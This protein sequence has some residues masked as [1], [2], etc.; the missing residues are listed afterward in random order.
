MTV[1][2][3]VGT[4]P[5][6]S[7]PGEHALLGRAPEIAAI[8]ALL[9]DP[10]SAGRGLLLRGPA[11]SGTSAL[12]SHARALAASRETPVLTITGV[13]AEQ[14]M[15][16][17]GLHQL[18][19]T[20]VGARRAA[21]E[22]RFA[23]A[24]DTFEA[25]A[26]L[27][28]SGPVLILAD[29]AELI[30]TA[31]LD[32]LGFVARRLS[33]T[34]VR[35]L[36]AARDGEPTALDDA[37]LDEIAVQPLPEAVARDL[38]RRTAPGLGSAWRRRILADAEGLPLA[39]VEL[40][41]AIAADPE[42]ALSLPPETLPLTPR[43]KR[44]GGCGPET[45]PPARAL[46]LAA[47]LDP[48]APLP[49][50]LAAGAAV[51]GEPV[52]LAALD[53]SL[54][55][56]LVTLRE[57]SVRFRRAIDRAAVASSASLG[58]RH[59]AHAALAEHVGDE[60]DSRARHLAAM[61]IEPDAALAA[62]VERAASG[63]YATGDVLDAAR[64]LQRSAELSPDDE[65]RRRRLT[66]A[67]GQA[68]ELGFPRAALRLLDHADAAQASSAG[69]ARTAL[70]RRIVDA[71]LWSPVITV[72]SLRDMGAEIAAAG[73][74]DV[75]LDAL[76]PVALKCWWSTSSPATR[77]SLADT[78]RALTPDPDDPRRLAI[79]GLADG[80]E[81]GPEVLERIAGLRP[82]ELGDPLR[83]M[84][85]GMAASGVGAWQIASAFLDPAIA[86][87]RAQ[88]RVATLTRA[89]SYR[90]WAALSTGDWT[91]ATQACDEVGPLARSTQQPQYLLLSELIAIN[92]AALRGVED[93][94]EERIAAIEGVLLELKQSSMLA[95]ARLAR[96]A[97]AL[98]EGRHDDAFEH[99][100][101]VFDPADMPFH[102]SVR[103]WAV[104]DLVDA[105]VHSGH[106]DAVA[107]IADGLEPL[108]QQTRGT[109]LRAAWLCTRPLLAGDDEADECFREAL[110]VELTGWP[111][112]RARTLFAHGVWLRRQRQ[113]AESRRPLRAARDLFDMLGAR[114]WS[115][116]A[117]QELR[118]TGETGGRRADDSREQLTAQEE[119][120]ARLAAGGMSN[121][122]I[123]ERLFLSHRTIGSHLY[124]IYPK[125]GISSRTD[126]REA[127]DAYDGA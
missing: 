62:A 115:E 108:A 30:D 27:S 89:L 1:A 3:P 5:A 10:P 99:L 16:Y 4:E 100:R 55:A 64:L 127:L 117:R 69:R 37:R 92:V 60:P 124:R 49:A 58:E 113:V 9:D 23:V 116:R 78:A 19:P 123:G 48:R 66:L 118:A 85:V 80:D 73:D 88:G 29:D 14:D 101:P 11:G 111:Y 65:E 67:A 13:A 26:R 22:D 39:I 28:A 21:G 71:S 76:V 42:L 84:F 126:L 54:A 50:V 18:L 98:G 97:A 8:E 2:E 96:A 79:L 36:A 77:R 86:G 43:L 45:A 52:D 72:R 47:S 119:Q 38:L 6:G 105:G 41:Q 104:L 90:A 81:T 63:A 91:T 51:C 59:A 31:T 40:G 20:T 32:V 114:R 75:A 82:H 53:P 120:I 17:A 61:A 107:A 112:L 57:G 68:F 103:T 87:L 24:T 74:A 122:E 44:A 15:P 35:L 46:L 106:H 110:G 94:L 83:T 25:L 121:R 56:G 102:A 95:P 70:Q 12:L 125:L 34:G 93:G 109:L 7:E 33:A